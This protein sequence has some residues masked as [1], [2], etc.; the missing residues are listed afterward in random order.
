MAK[1]PLEK[2]LYP[3]V[4]RWLRRHFRCFRCV[5]NKGLRYSRIDVLGIRDVGTDFSGDVETIAVEVKRGSTPFTNAAGQTVGYR[6]YANRV[7][8][9]DRRDEPFNQ[10]ELLIAT[11]LGIGLI[12]IKGNKCREIL[13]SPIHRPLPQLQV[14]LFEKLQL[15]TCTLCG[16]LFELGDPDASSWH[17]VCI[18]NVQRA[19]HLKK[20]LLYGLREVDE[21]KVKLGLDRGTAYIETRR[22][23]CPDCVSLVLGPVHTSSPQT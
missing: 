20:G 3:L 17:N 23:I 13:S 14:R 7:Y 6:V 1:K 8:L 9:A 22:L 4:G 10:D 19:A 2:T 11:N 21:R 15:G 16:S 5:T 12:Q 18:E